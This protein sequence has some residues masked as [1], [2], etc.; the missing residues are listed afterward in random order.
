MTISKTKKETA[1]A[2]DDI[3]FETRALACDDTRCVAAEI[4]YK[5]ISVI[6]DTVILEP[7]MDNC[8]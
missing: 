5:I 6:K 3:L 2:I 4:G 7:C 8:T 1:I